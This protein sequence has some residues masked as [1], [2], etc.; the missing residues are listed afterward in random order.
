MRSFRCRNPA[1]PALSPVKR[2]WLF[3]VGLFVFAAIVQLPAAWIAPWLA[4]ASHQHWRLGAVEGTLWQG[5]ATV[6]GFDREGG[7]WR[8]GRGL[9]WRTAWGEMLAWPP[10]L[11][12]Q[13]DLDEGGGARLAA[14]VRSWSIQRLDATLPAGQIAALLPG[15]LGDYGWYGTMRGRGAEFGCR[16][17]LPEC[18][19]QIELT[20]EQAGVAQIPGPPLGDYRLR[21]TAEGGAL[22]LDLATAR[23]R[24]QITG[25]GELSAGQLRF[26][27]E[28]S[29]M[30]EG[31]DNLVP[32]LVS[33]GRPGGAP[34]RYVIEYRE[35]LR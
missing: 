8:D 30:G 3:G 11:N 24:L 29:A 5:R 35:T 18:A 2:L 1:E 23:G 7:G 22:R 33:V 16:W 31:A 21:L 9:R 25:A 14:G 32:I 28:A 17:S 15:T 34:G 27:G 20:W 19:G 6:Y 26:N 4:Q 12:V 13:V 10:R